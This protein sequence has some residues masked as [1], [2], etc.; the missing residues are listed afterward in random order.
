VLCQLVD[1]NNTVLDVACRHV[2]ELHLAAAGIT[3]AGTD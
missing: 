2:V 3:S 1:L